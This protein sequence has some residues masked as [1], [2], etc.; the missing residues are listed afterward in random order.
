MWV[1]VVTYRVGQFPRYPYR[2][3]DVGTI[4]TLPREYTSRYELLQPIPVDFERFSEEAVIAHFREAELSVTG[5]DRRDA[6]D[7]LVSWVIDMFNDLSHADSQT[8]GPTPA[9]QRRVLQQYLRHC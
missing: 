3:P 9:M 7:D 4:Q 5:L 6:Q 1:V 2:S 8:L